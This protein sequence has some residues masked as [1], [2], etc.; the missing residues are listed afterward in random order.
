MEILWPL[1]GFLLGV[2]LSYLILLPLFRIRLEG[3]KREVEESLRR[4]ALERS[5]ATLKGRI[6]EQMAPL[7]P[8][9]KY[10]PADARFIGSPVDYVIF[11][12]H[13]R[14]EP[15][16]VVFLEVK[17]GRSTLTPLERKLKEVVE[18]GRVRWETLEL[19]HP[20]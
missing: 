10:E 19:D 9:F 7:L 8:Q 13:S 18:G 6:G 4:E 17:T 2:V 16:G 1:L 12:G 11:E 15:E 20:G 3:W 5:R 14:G